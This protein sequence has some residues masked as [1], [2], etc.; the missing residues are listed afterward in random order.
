MP[1]AAGSKARYP[2][3][4]GKGVLV[5]GGGSGI[6][7]E[8]VRQFAGQG[9]RLAF[10]DIDEVEG[11]ALADAMGHAS[12]R[13]LF[14]HCDLTDLGMVSASL[15]RVERELGGVD[16][17]INNAANDD[18]H[19]VAD[20]TPAYWDNR[21]AVN[22]RHY[23]FAAQAVLPGMRRRGHGAIVNLGS[24]AWHLALPSLV[25]YE[26]AKAGIEGMTRA[27]AREAGQD[28]VRVVTVVPGAVV[29]DRQRLL[30]R[31]G[32]EDASIMAAQ[33]LKTRVMPGD[34]AALVLFLAS[35]DAR[36]CTGHSYF[37]DAGW[38]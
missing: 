10:V 38:R 16:I 25:L 37:V 36:A 22:L 17:L 24:I 1:S 32:D 6:G 9:A 11:A 8:L 34:V 7:A 5:T 27:L 33:M 28:G 23:F 3:L 30:W 35:D 29:T 4:A 13:P 21:M 2:S 12:H 26:T 14:E 20:V 18:R 31:N 19:E 15:A